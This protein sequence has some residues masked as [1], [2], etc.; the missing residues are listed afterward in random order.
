VHDISRL[1]ADDWDKFSFFVAKL[2]AAY[3]LSDVIT[4]GANP[5]EIRAQSQ[6]LVSAK[7][8]PRKVYTDESEHD[9]DV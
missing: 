6:F 7:H 5:D 1:G 4:L 8:A 2:K 3:A 9:F